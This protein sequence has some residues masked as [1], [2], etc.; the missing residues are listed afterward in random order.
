MV[1]KHGSG[2]IYRSRLANGPIESL[3]RKAKDLKRLGHE[4]QNFEHF[5]T[6][7]LFAIHDNPVIN[8]V[9]DHNPLIYFNME[10]YIFYSKTQQ[11]SR[12]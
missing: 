11:A 7:F 2:K 10:D 1:E 12:K 9:T 3:N 4:Y 8:S 6:R 5:R